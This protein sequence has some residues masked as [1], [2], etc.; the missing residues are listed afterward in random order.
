MSKLKIGLVCGGPSLERGISI[1]SARS[2]MDHL[3]LHHI[4]LY[5]VSEQLEVYLLKPEHIYSNTP[6]DF[7][8]K[9]HEI[10]KPIKESSWIKHMQSLDIILPL[11]HGIYGEDGTLQQLLEEN[12]IPY[13][14]SSAKSCKKMF[15]KDIAVQHLQ[16]FGYPTLPVCAADDSVWKSWLKKDKVVVKPQA[17]GSSIGVSV[18]DTEQ[19]G[20]EAVV[21]LSPEKAIVEPFC[22]GKEFTVMVIETSNGPCAL[23]PTEISIDVKGEIY[24][25][26][27][28]YLPTAN[29]YWHCPPRFSEEVIQQIR[30]EA[31]SLFTL[32]KMNDFVRM[33]GW[34]VEDKVIFS[35]FNPI[36]GMEQN[37]FMF[38]QASRIGMTHQDILSYIIANACQRYGVGYEK[39]A[40]S[41]QKKQVIP[42]LM[43]GNSEERQVSLMSGTNVWLKLRQS[44]IYKP[45]PYFLDQYHQ[46]WPLPYTYALNHT[47]EEIYQ[48]LLASKLM[49]DSITPYLQTIRMEMGL[50][51]KDSELVCPVL[52]PMKLEQ[53][54]QD[55]A[56]YVFLAL[57]GGF[58][59][60]GRLQALLTSKGV[61]YNGACAKVSQLGMDKYLFA[62]S[63]NAQGIPNL[64]ALEK[65]LITPETQWQ[66]IANLGKR[67]VL[68][69]RDQGCSVGVLV[70]EDEASFSEYRIGMDPLM[71]YLAEKY[72]KTDKLVMQKEGIEHQ[73]ETYWLELTMVVYEEGGQYQALYPSITVA[74]SVVL[75]MEEKFQGGT[76]INITPPAILS[77]DL[78]TDIQTRV[79]LLAEKIGIKHYSRLDF[80]Y[81]MLS[82]EIIIIEMNS[83]PA[84]TPST[85][86]YHQMLASEYAVSPTKGLERLIKASIH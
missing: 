73:K 49:H 66:D 52:T 31:Q 34:V 29:T 8:F 15:F 55:N 84:L 28:K 81:H 61:R 4:T 53:F 63:V 41:Q 20:Q 36:S 26:R 72:I 6:E 47:V 62:K 22:H 82:H 24:D 7:D 16:T 18:V 86:L 67:I 69:P 14:G 48:N 3:Y 60:D 76:G 37:S 54:M 25:Y 46:V 74:K 5:Y 35:D 32:F 70:V 10:S 50:D 13:V 42:I 85:V 30:Q 9:L 78:I 21:N 27:R 19:A 77:S 1:N 33:D 58:G 80:F 17:G 68:K 43:G 64:S 11:I 38:L 12:Q 2:V 56:D 79:A 59:E 51:E 44:D 45:V 75:S 65:V 39:A 71:N 40:L 57:H 23:I 83:L